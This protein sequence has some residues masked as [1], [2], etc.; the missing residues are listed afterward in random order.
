MLPLVTLSKKQVRELLNVLRGFELESKALMKVDRELLKYY[1][2]T[3]RQ[4]IALGVAGYLHK[5]GVP[6]YL[7]CNLVEYL[8]EL[9]GGDE[10]SEMR[11]YAVR[12]TCSKDA[13]SDQVS[14]SVKLLDA[15]NGDCSVITLLEGEFSKLGYRFNSNAR[16]KYSQKQKPENGK[17]SKERYEYVQKYSNDRLLAEAVIVGG[18][19]CFAVVNTEDCQITLEDEI[20]LNDSSNTV[21]KAP[22]ISSY[23]TKPYS[24]TSTSEFENYL[25]KARIETLDSLYRKVKPIWKKHIDADD[26]HISLCAADTIFTYY[27]DKIGMTHYIFFIGDNDSGKSNN[28]A[29]IHYLG[30]RN[31]MNVGMSVANVYQFLGSRDEGVGT[32]CEDESDDIDEDHDKMQIAKSGYTKGYPV[33]KIVITPYGRSQYNTFCFEA[34]AAE[35]TP[36]VVK[37]K[38][39]LQR[40]IKLKC[41]AGLP[42][43][44][45]LEVT[46]PAGD[47]K[48]LLL[49]NELYDVRRL[50]FCYCRLLYHKDRIPDIQL[51]LR[52]RE[53]QLF[54]PRNQNIR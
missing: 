31:M 8:I 40:I 51:N 27:Q 5:H 46:N 17:K 14:G 13:K 21:L 6:Q 18:K 19:P 35:K 7:I 9:A 20:P 30:Y 1:H 47:H 45:I 23:I 38:G 52:N 12:D 48:F 49:L 50:L 10:E 36:D 26:F 32:I 15:V 44:D 37:S 4:N 2:P 41:S 25:H 29:I 28:L 22:D 34:Y 24:F 16:T 11:Y 42:Q 43:Y 33:T 53:N 39:F 54:K 3:N